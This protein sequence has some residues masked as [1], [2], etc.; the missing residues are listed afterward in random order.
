[1]EVLRRDI[2]LKIEDFG[3]D[4]ELDRCIRAYYK[5][6]RDYMAKRGHR[7]VVHTREHY[8]PIGG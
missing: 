5:L 3:E 6:L 1:M 8:R 2:N 7:W 4:P